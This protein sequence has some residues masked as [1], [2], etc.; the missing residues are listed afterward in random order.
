MRLRKTKQWAQRY[1]GRG[2]AHKAN[3][4]GKPHEE[5]E[6]VHAKS[7]KAERDTSRA[8]DMADIVSFK[9]SMHIRRCPHMLI[10][11]LMEASHTK[12]TMFVIACAYVAIYS[13]ARLCCNIGEAEAPDFMRSSIG[14]DLSINPF[15]NTHYSMHLII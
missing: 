13:D 8:Q 1:K 4:T 10:P 7:I 12:I 5:N 15:I 6:T 9:N 11:L 14:A 3:D 2:R